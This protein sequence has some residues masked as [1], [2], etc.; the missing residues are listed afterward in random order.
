MSKDNGL[1][2]INDNEF[3]QVIEKG[4]SLVDFW[5]PW[6]YPCR[7][8]GPILEK[9]AGQIGEKARIYKMNV[10]ENQMTP[11]KFQVSAIPTLILFKD[12]QAIKHFVGV[13]DEKTL[14]QS[15]EAV[16]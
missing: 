12:G 5:A 4:I 3:S 6:C 7:M 10:D 1:N 9:V 15:I 11:G 13:Q 16:A 8:Q 2:N 14:V